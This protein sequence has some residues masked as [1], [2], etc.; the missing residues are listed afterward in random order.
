MAKDRPYV[1]LVRD[2]ETDDVRQLY[3]TPD[4]FTRNESN[5]NVKKADGNPRK[6]WKREVERAEKWAKRKNLALFAAKG[7]QARWPFVVKDTD[8]AWAN[9]ELMNRIDKV[10]RRRRRYIWG[11]ELK[12][13]AHRQWELRMAYLN[14]RGNLAARCC[15][16]Y[17]GK[18]SW[19]ACG[20]NPTSDHNRGEAGD[21]SVLHSGRGGA[22]TNVGNDKQARAIMRDEGLVLNVG[23]EPWHAVR[24]EVDSTWRA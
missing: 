6:F 12:R 2:R 17:D 1:V 10:G 24:K 13:T 3:R 5:P 9:D 22:Y 19:A 15:T 11:G 4:G 16:K 8:T 14:G 18:H 7:R 23:G 21:I 20:K